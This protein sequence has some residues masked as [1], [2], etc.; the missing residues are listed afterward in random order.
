[1]P[2]LDM[3]VWLD[4]EAGDIKFQHYEK[5]MAS[6]E[7]M[8]SRS[9]QSISC[10]NSV[11]TQE[12][13][14]RLM[15]SSPQL[16]WKNEVAPIISEYMRRMMEAGYPEKYRRDT[17]NRALRIYD[18]MVGDDRDGIR[19]LYRPKEWNVVARDLEKRKKK[20][21]WSTRGGH[22]AQIF[23]PPTPNGEL[24][25]SLQEIADNEA[26]AGIHFNV[27][28]T[29]GDFLKSRVQ[30][31][32]LAETAGCDSPECMP[33]KSDRGGG[34]SCR[35][36]GVNYELECQ[37]CPD[38]RKSLYLGESARN[39]YTRGAEHMDNYRTGNKKS[40]MKKH[41][42]SEHQGQVGEYTAKVTART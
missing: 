2:I 26:E 4:R 25:K 5:P 30:K 12:I 29:G 42:D 36:C 34:G 17:L 20:N 33:C 18:K 13:L 35:G 37:L 39:L 10:K 32:N 6:R 40:F 27:I 15:N 31:S 14:R 7:V 21:D 11:H 24:A 16:D 1:M 8:H 28:E 23:V 9:A 22:I 41:Q 3:K 19:P 38:G